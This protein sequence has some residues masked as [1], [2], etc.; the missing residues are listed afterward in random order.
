MMLRYH[1]LSLH[2]SVFRAMTGLSVAQ[3]AA[4]DADFRPRFLEAEGQ[5]LSCPDRQARDC[6]I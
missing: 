2:P 1:Q 4:L 6:P 3:F 5:R